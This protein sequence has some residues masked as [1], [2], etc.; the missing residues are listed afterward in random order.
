MAIAPSVFISA[1]SSDLHSTR[2]VVAKLFTSMGYTPVWQDIAATDAGKPRFLS[3][4]DKTFRS[5]I[6]YSPPEA[7]DDVLAVHF[8]VSEEVISQSY[9]E[10]SE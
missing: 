7:G 8:A 6:I 9:R 1:I 2:D 5:V 4:S 10:I 3:G